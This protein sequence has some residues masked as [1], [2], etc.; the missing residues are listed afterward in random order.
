M[1]RLLHNVLAFAL[2]AVLSLSFVG[3][4][5]D[6]TPEPK[7]HTQTLIFYFAGTDLSLYF[8]K[9]ISAIKEAL[10]Q[11]IKGKSR[12]MLFFQQS[13]KNSAE[14]IELI[15]RNGMCEEK[16]LATHDLPARMDTE[17]LSYFLNEIMRLAP[18]DS[19]SLIIGSHGLGWIPIGARPNDTT[20][21]LRS[22][23]SQED[24]WQQTG[25][26]KTR[27]IGEESNVQNAFDI[28]TLSA[29]LNLTGKKMEYILFDACFM[30]NVESAY[31]LRNNT[32]YIVGSVCE[33]MGDG[34]PYTNIMPHLLTNNGQGYDL[35]LACQEFNTFYK[36]RYGYSGSIS[37][38]DCSELDALATEM[39][40][41]NQG[42]RLEYVL[43]NLQFYEGQKQHVFFDLGDYVNN[44]CAD[45]TVKESFRQQLERT[46]ITKY[47]LD[48][49][50]SAYGTYG[51]QYSIDV[52]AYSGL[53]TSAP[54]EVYVDYYKTTDW[55]KATH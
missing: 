45:E 27:F 39:K 34:F 40:K 6:D 2:I 42:L 47:T 15:Y 29:A 18:A 23:A 50:Y 53:N 24:F 32:K 8:Y 30:A 4:N 25:G 49:F 37:I 41:V 44:I 55:Y 33:I 16:K 26:M 14:I 38:I 7:P 3:C 52:D 5:N 1:K 17:N 54:A 19:Y 36:S 31:V 10:R 48:K 51:R 22:T 9:N 21:S 11:D 46:V 13:E 43:N 12:V 28:S 35:D 20:L